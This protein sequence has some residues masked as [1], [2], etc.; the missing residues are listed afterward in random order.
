METPEKWSYQPDERLAKQVNPERSDFVFDRQP[1]ALQSR[2]AQQGLSDDLSGE[3]FS[4]D[5]HEGKTT[6]NVVLISG[7]V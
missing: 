7:M 6:N 1:D 5:D 2:R 4:A 3:N